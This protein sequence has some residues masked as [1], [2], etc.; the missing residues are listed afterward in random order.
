MKLMVLVCRSNPS[1]HVIV[2]RCDACTGEKDNLIGFPDLA[3]LTVK[4]TD[5]LIRFLSKHGH[6]GK[7]NKGSSA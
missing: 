7:R 6:H 1:D 4:D 3:D 5:S 2:F